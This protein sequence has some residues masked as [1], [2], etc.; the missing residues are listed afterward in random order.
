MAYRWFL[1]YRLSEELSHFST[2]SYNF[3]HRFTEETIEA[4]FRWVLEETG[5]AGALTP[6]AVFIDGTHI[7]ASANLNR[8]IK[9]EVAV[10]AKR[11]QEEL[12][13]EV[14]ADRETHGK[15]PFDNDDSPNRKKKGVNTS[16]KKLVQRKKAG[17]TRT[18][19]CL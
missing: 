11:C 8:K 14:N 4:V 16:K 7:K 17:Q 2:V 9:Q 12:L 15:K 19:V 3:L 13:A 5:D 10:A 6:A 18:V 1:K